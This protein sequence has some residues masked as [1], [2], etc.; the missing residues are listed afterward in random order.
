[1]IK[2]G[3]QIAKAW[4]IALECTENTETE[5]WTVCIA[6]AAPQRISISDILDE[7]PLSL[8]A[9]VLSGDC[10]LRPEETVVGTISDL[11]GFEFRLVLIVGCDAGS[12]PQ[13]G[14]PR[15]EVWR[16]ALRLYVAM[17]RGR[18][19]VY[20]LHGETASEFITVFGDT[21]ISRSEPI[22]KQYERGVPLHPT[23]LGHVRPRPTSPV[24]FDWNANAEAWFRE[25]EIEA[26]RRYFAKY[27]YRDNLT[28]HEWMKPRALQHLDFEPFRQLR[29][30]SRRTITNIFKILRAKNVITGEPPNG[31]QR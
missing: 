8:A 11:K 30:V 27:V 21:V 22:F 15:A 9:C 26:L 3:N 17:T 19:Q 7:R 1:V 2:T 24:D 6:T 18:D 13:T 12:F 25:D 29:N 28:F 20:L 10:I 14:V 16:D 4:E 23:P 31:A 5:P